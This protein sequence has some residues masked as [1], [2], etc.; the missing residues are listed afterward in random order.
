MPSKKK[1]PTSESSIEEMIEAHK[2]PPG[3]FP[4]EGV[5]L[6]GV[7]PE[8]QLLK[9]QAYAR[10]LGLPEPESLSQAQ[11]DEINSVRRTPIE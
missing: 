9:A 3:E 11:L 8:F 1:T 10:S 2:T 7:D 6:A 5:V 4:K